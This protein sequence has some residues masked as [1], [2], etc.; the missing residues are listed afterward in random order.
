MGRQK[1]HGRTILSPSPGLNA[2]CHL[3]PRLTSWAII[4]RC[5]A[6]CPAI[7]Q[8]LAAG[9]HFLR[10]AGLCRQPSAAQ[11][12]AVHGPC[13]SWSTTTMSNSRDCLRLIPP[14]WRRRNAPKAA[15]ATMAQTAAASINSVMGRS[16]RRWIQRNPRKRRLPNKF[17]RT[18]HRI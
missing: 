14:E 12:E 10:S 16:P 17:S 6:A 1:I 7:P 4:G 18:G 13:G 5:S 3:N 9:H 8:H 2:F 11:R 15:G